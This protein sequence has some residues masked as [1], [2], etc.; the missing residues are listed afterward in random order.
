MKH[1]IEF[2]L[3]L[4]KNPYKGLY[5]VAEGIDGC[6]K[7]TQVKRLTK[8]FKSIGK[9]VVFTREPRKKGLIGELVHKVLLGKEKID[10]KAIQYLFAADRVL[11]QQD[12]VIP[13]LKKGKVVISDR[14]FWSAMVYGILDK[15]LNYNEKDANRLLVAYSILSWYHEFIV[16]DYTFYLNISA[17]T[18]LARVHKKDEAREIYEEKNK[19]KKAAIGYDWVVSKFGENIITLDGELPVEE[20]TKEIIKKIKKI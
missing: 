15:E 10:L 11:N 3:E 7:S 8:Y 9:E 20:V 4:K 17:K 18:S 1:H 16:P 12:V 19:I 14:S 5:L 6:G 13:A 2:D